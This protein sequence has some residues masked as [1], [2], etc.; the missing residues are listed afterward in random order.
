VKK[1]HGLAALLCACVLGVAPT[2]AN[3]LDFSGGVGVGGLLAGTAPR[4]AVSPHVSA[5]W[6]I[7]DGFIVAAH[8]ECSIIPSTNALGVGVYNQ[9][10]AAV[11]YAWE[12]RDFS[13][14]PSLSIYSMPACG[15]KLCGR[16]AGLAPG[17]HAQVNVYLVGP[18]GLSVSG[19]V[20]WIGGKSLVLPG[21]LAAMVVAGPV[22]RWRLK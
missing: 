21:G 7:R 5:S 18:W 16:V 22:L 4:L 12:E 14:G 8:D 15:P 3:A 2:P 6:Q 20:D 17:G 11:G 19:N 9:M 10:I 1:S 13:V